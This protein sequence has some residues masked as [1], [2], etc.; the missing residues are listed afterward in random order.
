MSLKLAGRVF[1]IVAVVIVVIPVAVGAPPMPVFI[2]PTMTAAPAIFASF[3]QLLASVIRLPAVT[4]MMLDSFVKTMIGFR[5]TALAT[6]VIGAQTRCADEE[7]E[8]R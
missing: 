3:V 1:A 5:D 8:S 4:A 2:P 6:I 7:Q